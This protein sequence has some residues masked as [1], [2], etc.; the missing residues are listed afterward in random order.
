MGH[1]RFIGFSDTV[2]KSRWHRSVRSPVF[3]C[4]VTFA[5]CLNA[6]MLGLSLELTEPPWD[7]AWAVLGHIFTAFFAFEMVL[8]LACFGVKGYFGSKKESMWN[9]LD[10][11]CAWFGIIDGW[12]MPIFTGSANRSSASVFRLLRV[13]RLAEVVRANKHLAVL[14]EG[15]LASLKSL[16]WVALLLTVVT[17]AFAVGLLMGGIGE[18]YSVGSHWN[19]R[20]FGTVF[21]AMVSLFGVCIGAEWSSVIWPVIDNNAY[22]TMLVFLVFIFVAQFGFLNIIV[23]VIVDRTNAASEVHKEEIVALEKAKQMDIIR[24]IGDKMDKYDVNRSGGLTFEEFTDLLLADENRELRKI[25]KKELPLGFRARDLHA[26]L[27]NDADG[28]LTKQEFEDGIEQLISATPFQERILNR[29][30]QAMMQREIMKLR[31]EVASVLALIKAEM[32]SF[33]L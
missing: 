27:E 25:V 18:D 4:L 3:R 21:R 31:S 10:F 17:Y 24:E 11:I 30:R 1:C 2:G 22:G 28:N 14:A 26:I 8:K 19:E 16:I 7:T 23:G 32:D 29:Y 33:R 9:I 20:Y 12:L 6:V 13:V 15:M 5:I